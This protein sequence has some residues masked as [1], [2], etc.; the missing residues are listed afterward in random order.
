MAKMIA[1][2]VLTIERDALSGLIKRIDSKFEKAVKAIYNIK[3][4]VIV[5]GMGN[6]PPGLIRSN[7]FE[8]SHPTAS[9]GS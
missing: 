2:K 7:R 1:K 3:G 8:R 9:I 5:T 4:R 6:S